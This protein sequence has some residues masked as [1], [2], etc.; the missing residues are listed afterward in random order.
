MIKFN[1]GGNE[2]SVWD[3]SFEDTFTL[4]DTNFPHVIRWLQGLERRPVENAPNIKARLLPQPAPDDKIK[5]LVEG[6]VSLAVRSPMNREAAVALA[7]RWNGALQKDY[8]NSIIGMNL[9]HVQRM[10]A[11]NIG[12]RGK[13]A[14]L[15]SPGREFIFGD[16]FFH[17]IL[18]PS[19]APHSPEILVPLTPEIAVLYAR[20]W[21][22]STD[23]KLVTI[24]LTDEEVRFI[25]D[26][27]QVYSRQYIF[28]RSQQPDIT[29]SFR[30]GRH[31]QYR[32]GNPV[33]RLI[34]E[35]SG[36]PR[37][38]FGF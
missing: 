7:E 23:P 25:N 37:S 21:Q 1:K 34:A 33:D 36:V 15:Y 29:E 26:T 24:V 11:D 16:G 19:T 14:V 30:L 6:L 17:N 13:F 32:Y 5:P 28:Y 31:Q 8:R 10:V 2:P 9:R 12:T 35:L 20:P 27:M 4:A 3:H 38:R 22:Y 18:S